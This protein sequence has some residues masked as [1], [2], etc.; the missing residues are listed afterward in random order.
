MEII[1][2]MVEHIRKNWLSWVLQGVPAAAVL[3]AALWNL[4]GQVSTIKSDIESL[5]TENNVSTARMDSMT[6]QLDDMKLQIQR[7]EDRLEIKGD[8]SEPPPRRHGV[9]YRQDHPGISD[10]PPSYVR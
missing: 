4:G 9:S 2:Y 6:Q 5:K 10:L 3:V 8:I 7:L 1:A